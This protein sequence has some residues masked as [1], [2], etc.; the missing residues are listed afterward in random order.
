LL[1]FRFLELAPVVRGTVF[2]GIADAVVVIDGDGHIRDL[3]TRAEEML[4]APAAG[5]IGRSLAALAGLAPEAIYGVPD[6]TAVALGAGQARRYFELSTSP[7]ANRETRAPCT[8]LVL[9]DVTERTLTQ[10]RIEESEQNPNAAYAVDLHGNVSSANSASERTCGYALHEVLGH[11]FLALLAPEDRLRAWRHFRRAAHGE[12]QT[13]EASIVHRDGRRVALQVTNLP[14]VVAGTITGVYGMAKDITEQQRAIEEIRKLE[15]QNRRLVEDANDMILVYDG[16]GRLAL[17]NRKFREV[18]GY[19]SEEALAVTMLD[20]DR[21]K[22]VNDTLGHHAGDLLLAQVAE[23]L[24]GMLRASD[25]VARLGGDE[26]A[27]LLKRTDQAQ[28]V[29][30]AVALLR[31]IEA[32]FAIEGQQVDVGASIGVVCAGPGDE[33]GTLMRYADIAMY[34]AKRT[35]SGHA[36]YSPEQDDHSP[37]RLALVSDL[38]RA[39][40]QDQLVLHYQPKL[41]LASGRLCR[42]EALVRRQR[43]GHGLVP[44]DQSIPLAERTGLIRPLSHWVLNAALRQSRAWQDAGLSFTVAVNLAAQNLHEPGLPDQIGSLLAAWSVKPESLIVDVTETGVLAEP[45][46]AAATLTRLRAMG[47]R[48]AI[49]DFG[50]GNA[51]LGYLKNLP[52]DQLTIDRSFVTDLASNPSDDAIVSSTIDLA[53][54]LGLDVVAES[55]EDQAALDR[56]AVLGC[57]TAQGYYLCRPLPA[58]QLMAWLETAPWSAERAVPHAPDAAA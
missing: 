13:F 42:V 2:Q 4:G 23:R 58:E 25:T 46:R 20:L 19:T 27:V 21:F 31:A 49:D 38:R 44:P 37:E 57:D 15:A 10:R 5:V 29:G 39:I 41:D 6:G 8:L 24:H 9:R 3:N 22:E 35:H 54:R 56:L 26:F 40:E 7:V 43:P 18:M 28:A 52:I 32:P 50:T 33:P 53:H 48:I 51:A 12:P 45:E 14:I 30:V 55:V 1:R 11:R 36:V 34:V 16:A 17:V 47:V